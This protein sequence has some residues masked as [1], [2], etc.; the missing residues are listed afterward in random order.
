MDEWRELH[1]DYRA[2]WT[3]RGQGVA[4]DGVSWFVSQNDSAPG[5]SRYS[6]DF[7]TLEAR[8][9][10]PRWDAGHVGAVSVLDDRVFVALEGPERVITFTPELDEISSVTVDRPMESDFKKHLAWC[11]INPG[12]GLLYTC[13]WVDAVSLTAYHPT[14]GSPTPEH[15]IALSKPVNRTQGGAFSSNGNLYL[16]SDDQLSY[17]EQLLVMLRLK[18]PSRQTFPGIHGF[19]AGTGAT[20]G[21]IPIV[22]RPLLPHFEEIEGMALGPMMIDGT[23]AHVHLA[24]LDKNQFWIRDD[25]EIR[26]FVVPDTDEL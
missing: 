25:V 5:V 26:S 10:I 11:A 9:D 14:T 18:K 19:D 8:V 12:S 3:G 21:Y 23:I 20:L 7:G 22:T 4:T 16:A 24:F 1:K 2:V 17:T 15:D 6:A 13:D